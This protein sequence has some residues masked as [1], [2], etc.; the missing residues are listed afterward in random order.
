[1]ET[2]LGS[3]L[4]AQGRYA[5]A[6]TALLGA[7]RAFRASQV[8]TSPRLREATSALVALYERWGRPAEAAHF[9][10]GL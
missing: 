6:E 2:V 3:C 8:E 10:A 4:L 9:R 1:M 7:H 5:E